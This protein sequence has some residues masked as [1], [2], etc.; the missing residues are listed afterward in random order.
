MQQCINDLIPPI[1]LKDPMDPWWSD[2]RA[3]QFL[4]RVFREF[5]ARLRLPNVMDKSDYH[6]L[7]RLLAR[8]RIVREVIEKLDAI[9]AVAERARSLIE[10][11]QP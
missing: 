2:E 10:N 1:A 6:E 3:S 4:E 8:E 11:E 7:V 9:C 5:T